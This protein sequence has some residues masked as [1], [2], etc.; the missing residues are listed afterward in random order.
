VDQPAFTRKIHQRQADNERQ[1]NL[2]RK[3]QHGEI[4]GF[5]GVNQTGSLGGG[6]LT[7]GFSGS[8]GGSL[9]GGSAGGGGDSGGSC[10]SLTGG[11]LGWLGGSSTGG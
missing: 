3:D 4:G 10:G 1:Q 7:G 6:S 2:P 8:L 5:W 11:F 9:T